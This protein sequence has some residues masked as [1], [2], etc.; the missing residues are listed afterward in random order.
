MILKSSLTEVMFTNETGTA[1]L[2]DVSAET[3]S[4][5]EHVLQTTLTDDCLKGPDLFFQVDCLVK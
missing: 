1:V 4:T 2:T 3:K 5:Y